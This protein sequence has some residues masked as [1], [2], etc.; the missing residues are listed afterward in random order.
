MEKLGRFLLLVLL[1]VSVWSCSGDDEEIVESV[2]MIPLEPS[3]PIPPVE[4]PDSVPEGRVIMQAFYWDV[5]AGGT[6]WQKIES[7]IPAWS[8]AGITAVWL[9][10]ANKSQSGGYSMGYDPYDYYD[11]GKY[12]QHGTVET[13]FGSEAELKSLIETAHGKK[14]EVIADIVINHNSG[15]ASE[16]NKWKGENTW[17]D[18]SPKSGKFIRHAEHFHPN[19]IHESDEGTFGGFPDLCLDNAYVQ[20]W[21][22]KRDDSVGK[23]YRD[24][25]GFDAWRFDYVKG[26]APWVVKEWNKAIGGFSVGEFWDGDV[27]KLYAWV[28]ES[29]SPAFDFPCFYKMDEAFDGNDF[30]KLN[31]DMLWKRDS[32]KA[33][34]FVANHD[35]EHHDG[36][37]IWNKNYAYAYIMTHPGTPCL[38]YQDY[39]E[40]LDKEAL[41]KLITIKRTLAKG[42]VTVLHIDNDEYVARR[43]GGSGLIVFLNGSDQTKSRK[44][45]TLWA[46][47]RIKDA[48]GNSDKVLTVNADGTVFV[49]CPKENY[50]VWT[51]AE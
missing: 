26:F 51:L 42:D 25:M 38:F 3:T 47:K 50:T 1:A 44:V 39:E 45:S 33:V 17:T 21:L 28:K 30:T 43:E 35:I 20:D 22:W 23:Y 24:V 8:D 12:N 5:P 14:L 36:A 34:T 6:W 49:E 41:N 2:P 31:S 10:P 16:Y 48:T 11:F 40:W 37:R 7:K 46:G 19:G 13:R 29:E 32:E 18:F 15:G 27:Q 4:K 9:P